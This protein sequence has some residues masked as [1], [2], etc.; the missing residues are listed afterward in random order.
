MQNNNDHILVKIAMADDH[1]LFR[2]SLCTI[3]NSW[4]NCKVILQAANGKQL[5]ESLNTKNLPDLALIDLNM[6]VMNG[7]D[8]LKAIKEKYPAIKLMVI[9]TYNSEEMIWQVI[10]CGAEGFISKDDDPS[11][12]KKG[13]VEMMQTGYFFSDHSASKMVRKF[14][15]NGKITLANSL[16]KKD[17]DFLK[18]LCPEK[19][20]KEIALVMNLEER[21]V[22]YLRVSLFEKFGAKSRTGLAVKAIEK[23]L[24]IYS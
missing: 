15:Q 18:Y 22:E 14:M 1:N 9:S 16:T 4:E 19:T 10:K 24:A 7:Y 17:I 23:G 20:Y 21:Q 13:V 5:I 11:R 8:T 6:P 12:L 3:I 2:E